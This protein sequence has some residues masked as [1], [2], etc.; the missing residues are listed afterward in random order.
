MRAILALA[1]ALAIVAPAMAANTFADVPKTH[2]AYD[3]IQKAV[4]AGILQ[5]YDGKFHGQ[6]LLNRYQ[7]AVIVAKLLDAVKSP[8]GMAK[9]ASGDGKTLQNIEA[10]TTEF[11]DELALLNTK[12]TTLEGTTQE[13][14]KDLEAIKGN[15][16]GASAGGLGFTAFLQVGLESTDDGSQG[17]APLG[18][19]L[20]RYSDSL[21][22]MFFTLPQAS[23]GVDKEVN[24]GVYFHAQFD[25]AS[26]VNDSTGGVQI[27]EAYFFVDEILGDIGGKV[28]AFALPLSMEHNGPFRTCNYTITPSFLNT[29]NEQWRGYGVQFQKVKDVQ[30][31]DI[32]WNFGIVSGTDDN[33]GLISGNFHNFLHA[34]PTG[35]IWTDAPAGINT[36]EN[37]DSFGYYLFIGKKPEKT[38]F[39]WNLAYFTN[40]GDNGI[41]T[42]VDPAHTPSPEVDYYQ[43]GFEWWNDQFGVMAQYADGGFTQNSALATEIDMTAWYLMVNFKMDDKNNVSL[44]YDSFQADRGTDTDMELSAITFA[45]NHKVT[46]NSLLQFEY[47]T[48][49]QDEGTIVGYED[50]E[51]D[52]IQIRYKVHF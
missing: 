49:D 36:G 5:G 4:D 12:V 30:P 16:G 34:G 44:R 19:P 35:G 41:D 23:I 47:I 39:G 38:G 14:K 45:F 7:M 51:D 13:L 25:Y 2:W 50:T 33:N 40:G 27:N 26:D 29:L 46:E 10:L 15:G 6:R 3:A 42:L 28:G 11:A 52:L 1:L 18:Y 48:P 17:A 43:V 31:A 24:P 22:S 8:E 21:D 20:T 9:A 37:D 32:V